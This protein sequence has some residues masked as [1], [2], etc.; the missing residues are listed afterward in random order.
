[1]SLLDVP[2]DTYYTDQSTYL[3]AL[4]LPKAWDVTHG[5]AAVRV[6]VI[7]SGATTSHPDLA[8]KVIAH[9]NAVT[10]TSS[11]TDAVG[12]GTMVSSMIAA[13]TDNSAGIAGAGWNTDLLVV[14]VADSHNAINDADVAEGVDWAVKHGADVIN[15]SLGGAAAGTALKT[16][17]AHAVNSDVVV[18]AAAGNDGTS[19]KFYPAALPGVVAVGATTTGGSARASFSQHGSW[20]DLAA[21]GVDIIGANRSGSGY[22][23]GDGT[24]FAAP[25]VSGVAALIRASRP[26]LS[27]S[28]V[29]TSMTAT[30]STWTLGFAH[31]MV[32]AYKALGYHL[33]LSG[34]NVSAPVSGDT[35]GSDITIA[36]TVPDAVGADHVSASL[37]G[38]TGSVTAALVG[39][40]AT[41]HLPAWGSAGTR[42]LR[43]VACRQTLCSSS[44][45]D[46][47]VVV[48]YPAPVLTSPAD[49]DH[50]TADWT[51]SA[52]ADAPTVRFLA[53]GKTL[54]TDTAAPFS[55]AVALGKL[56][57]GSHVIN[58]VACNAAGTLC[59][60]SNASNAA[61]VTV[62]H[63]TPTI[64][65]LSYALFSP[66]GDG[67]REH[68]TVTF[69]L[70]AAADVAMRVTDSNGA[71]VRSVP[72]GQ[73]EPGSHVWNWNGADT[74]GHVTSGTY[75]IHVDAAG[76][77]T[78]ALTGTASRSVR[79]DVIRPTVTSV[80]TTYGTFY[81][82]RDGYRDS[83]V[84]SAHVS[85]AAGLLVKV[86]NPSGATV[87][88][89][90]VSRSSAGTAKVVWRGLSSAGHAL[91]AG[92]YHFRF[93]V[94]DNAGN[95]TQGV[96]KAIT[97][98]TKKAV[99]RSWV[100]KVTARSVSG[101]TYQATDSASNVRIYDAFGAG[102][103]RFHASSAGQ[104]R[105]VNH[106][107]LP[108]AAQYVSV[109]VDAYARGISGGQAFL[110][111]LDDTDREVHGKTFSSS[112]GTH[113]GSSASPTAALLDGHRVRWELLVGNG[114]TYDVRSYTVTLTYLVLS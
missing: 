81:P 23:S 71:T 46:V 7:D 107:T 38:R 73:L 95:V 11:V 110:A 2:S 104:V 57:N 12:H 94:T 96:T 109:R 44:G 47:A 8:G 56:A 89:G 34:P 93:T 1:M 112:T 80:A 83:T 54:S 66:N 14:K 113:T 97:V 40:A 87:W 88:S 61:T 13:K 102:A 30:A 36:L 70:D 63:L 69:T 59:D 10:G 103:L 106:L 92:R 29:V 39:G 51:V 78:D 53:D 114:D 45:T 79:V 21:P 52:T 37:V 98:S 77:T 5:S 16:A 50:Q 85:E 86:T 24:S 6:A 19:A 42:T 4:D 108:S 28:G 99:K 60:V 90:R 49:G 27:A 18:V 67:V 55:S 22:V 111:F 100:K 58:A 82:H 101:D 33:T 17:I 62:A 48:D 31:G 64:S 9:Y 15:L 75:V 91:P 32:D 72:L 65:S 68:T 105:T 35:V 84:L 20:V 76:V 25:L 41:L 3:K 26:T 74:A 43:V